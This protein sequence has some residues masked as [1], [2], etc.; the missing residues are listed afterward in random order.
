MNS[1]K[2]NFIYNLIYQLLL[3]IFPLITVPY[4]SRVLG[5]D[6]VGIYSYTHSIVYYF[7]LITLLG[8]NNHGNR[9]IAKV[10]DNKKEL[11]K[12]FLSI[13]S[14][15]LVS[16]LLMIIIYSLYMIFINKNYID[17]AWIQIIYIIS[18]IFDINWFFFG[19][20]E[21]K[22]TITRNTLVKILSLVLIFVF[23]KSPND[24]II[25]TLIMTL[26]TLLSQLLLVPFLIKRIDI[27]KITYNDIKK[28]IKPVL[29]MFIPV[30]A[31]SIYRVM[32][33][34]ML[35]A[36]T[37]VSEVGLYEQADKIIIVPIAIISAL[38]TVMLPRISNLVAKDKKEEI[39]SY[40]EKS[41]KFIMFLSLPMCFGL[42]AVSDIFVPMFLGSEFTGSIILVKWMSVTI[43]FAS[44]AN[45]LR[46]QYLIPYEKDNIYVI[47]IILGAVI[48]VICNLIFIP[49]YASCGA[50]VGTIAAEFMVMLI[51]IIGLWKYL[52]IMEYFKSI[53][54]FAI[55]AVIM[56][57]IVILVSSLPFNNM[58]ILMIQMLIGGL[59]YFVLNINYI[60]KL[61][62]T[63]RHH[64]EKN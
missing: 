25:Y 44:F 58:I 61:L 18:A 13:Y 6:G 17:I 40:V 52:P 49:M 10:R 50:L 28:H 46:T 54:G 30:I 15:Q 9:S 31:V 5:T 47:S 60:S 55:K 36:M 8:I 43:L 42:I 12:T 53:F 48:N 14:I 27:V 7:M 62:L 11:S 19:L 56:F 33:K 3:F 16:G 2:K 23:V 22:V 64:N 32:D 51:Q 26:S 21:F 39:L 35:G 29:I 20:E 41:I 34:I 1:V 37:S 45:V 4:I 57:I 24:V 38:G 63:G 59:I